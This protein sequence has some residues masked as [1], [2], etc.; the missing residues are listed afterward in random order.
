MQ[1]FPAAEMDAVAQ[2]FNGRMGFYL[3]DI[4]TGESHQYAGDQRYPTASVCKVTVMAELF[5]QDAS[6]ELS[7]SDR[8]R[9]EDLYSPHGSGQLKLMQDEPS[10][11][12]LDYCRMMIT[13]SDN[14]ATDLLMGTVG[15][16]NINKFLD[17][18]GYP[19]TRTSVTLGRY[20]YRMTYHDDLPTN[21]AND[22]IIAKATA[23]GAN[24]YKSVSYTG[25]PDN[26]V[27]SPTEMGDFMKRLHN[28]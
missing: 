20:H 11:T 18:L 17:E 27:A 21:R 22:E 26:N 28:G 7:L 6:G 13:I 8:K 4:A 10:I 3:E 23:D 2:N 15:I 16:P 14:I 25:S 1:K 9:L 19:Q 5:R 12:L 24:D